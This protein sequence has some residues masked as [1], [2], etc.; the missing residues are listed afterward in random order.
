[1]NWELGLLLGKTPV[2]EHQIQNNLPTVSFSIKSQIFA[3][4]IDES[5]KS[6][7]LVRPKVS[8]KLRTECGNTS[9]SITYH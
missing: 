6:I 1:M 8:P 3:I 5:D 2:A 9:S 4:F 7:R